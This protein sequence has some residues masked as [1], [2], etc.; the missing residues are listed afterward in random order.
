MTAPVPATAGGAT[1]VLSVAVLARLA[2]T[3]HLQAG[4]RRPGPAVRGVA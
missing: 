1:S 4:A 3:S 2:A